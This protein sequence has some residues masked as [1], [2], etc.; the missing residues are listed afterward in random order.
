MIILAPRRTR[1]T[2]THDPASPAPSAAK[3]ATSAI[4]R[5][6]AIYYEHPRWFERLFSELENRGTPYRRVHAD[7]HTFDPSE[8]AADDSVALVFNRMS[9]SAY[10]REHGLERRLV[11]A[12]VDALRAVAR[13]GVGHRHAGTGDR[14]RSEILGPYPE[15]GRDR[16]LAPSYPHHTRTRLRCVQDGRFRRA[17]AEGVRLRRDRH[18]AWIRRLTCPPCPCQGR[19]P[20]GHARAPGS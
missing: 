4:A 8:L 10:R 14:R 18:R 13:E 5:P 6:I 20:S 17:P 2:M 16:R 15:Q 3:P 11:A 9:P 7:S 12:A 1:L 19:Y